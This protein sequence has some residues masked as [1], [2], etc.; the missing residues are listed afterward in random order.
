[1]PTF[2]PVVQRPR[3]DGQYLVYIRVTHNRKI[4]LINTS[5][6]VSRKSLS[7]TMEILSTRV[8]TY[9]ELLIAEYNR[10]LSDQCLDD[11]TVNEVLSF[12]KTQ[13]DDASFSDYARLYIQQII[14]NGN[15]RKAKDYQRA[16]KSLEEDLALSPVM[17]SH[18][19]P[20][21]LSKWIKSLELKKMAKEKY[22]KWVRQI[23]NAAVADL[24]DT[25]AGTNIIKSDPWPYVE[26]PTADK[27]EKVALSAEQCRDFFNHHLPESK[28]INPLPEI[29]RD[30]AKLILCLG[31]INTADLFLLKKN[32]YQDGII[33]YQRVKNRSSRA[34]E[35]YSEMRVEPFIR[36][37]FDKYLSDEEDEFLFNFHKRYC[38]TDSF[39]ANVNRGLKEIC[40]DMKIPKEL[41]YNMYTFRHTWS[42]IAQNDCGADLS[43]VIMGLY[44]KKEKKQTQENSKSD[45]H[46][47]WELNARVI[48]FIFLQTKKSRKG[49]AKSIDE[50][51]G[52]FFRIT[53]K[54]M[55][56]ATATFK[57]S[58]L[59][60]VKGIGFRTI[61][62]V[63]D[64]LVPKLPQTIPVG[65]NVLFRIKNCDTGREEV[66][67]HSKGKGF[68]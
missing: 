2:K 27:S 47:V 21:S 51:Q 6:V 3:K 45:F 36:P 40:K 15:L 4:G 66:Y 41:Y 13:N 14:D 12:L 25:E 18:L 67:E 48:D 54:T 17:F 39:S 34:G 63:I 60:S 46:Q 53:D 28:F 33:R 56:E 52:K 35:L 23:F 20:Q 58:E 30:V 16:V 44:H 32:D 68:N 43:D 31:G 37:V 24:N 59:A 50:T 26:I 42:S 7:K 22:P 38:D 64:A 10:M 29:S 1:M 19:T 55:I 61:D 49:R 8:L 9:C 5:K 65:C 11:W 62:A 57:G